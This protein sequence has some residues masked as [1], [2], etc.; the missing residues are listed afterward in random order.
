MSCMFECSPNKRR[1]AAKLGIFTTHLALANSVAF[2]RTAKKEINI[3]KTQFVKLLGM[4][5]LTTVNAG[6]GDAWEQRG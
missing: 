4:P 1:S 3:I 5:N 6:I 2:D